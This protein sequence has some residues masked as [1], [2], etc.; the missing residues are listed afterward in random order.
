MKKTLL[1]LFAA[2]AMIACAQKETTTT[3]TM[4]SE[5]APVTETAAT[6]ETAAQ[7]GATS[8]FATKA[9]ADGLMEVRLGEIAKQ[10]AQSSE[11]KDFASMMVADHTKSNDEL[12][13]IASTKNV[14]IT[15]GLPP[16]KQQIVER[17]SGLSGQEFDREYMAAM[18]DDHQKA[19]EM[20]QQA[21]GAADLDPEMKNFAAKSLPT[22][23]QHLQRAQTVADTLKK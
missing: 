7:P 23:Q 10:K 9:A 17:L 1:S 16:D 11:V 14:T 2:A 13:A 21:A 4:E 8:D 19:V 22:L 6:T 12:K 15:T 5:A 18:V 20:F 3:E